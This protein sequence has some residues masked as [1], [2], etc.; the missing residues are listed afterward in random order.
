MFAEALRHSGFE[1]LPALGL[2][3]FF[4][5]MVGVYLWVF[6]PRSA[7]AYESL[8]HFALRDDQ[9]AHEKGGQA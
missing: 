7:A 4:T 3:F 1:I 5:F 8:R 9:S 2:V 6:R